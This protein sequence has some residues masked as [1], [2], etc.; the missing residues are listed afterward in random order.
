MSLIKLLQKTDTKKRTFLFVGNDDLPI[1]E[2]WHS[3][4]DKGKV[5][6]TDFEMDYDALRGYLDE[7]GIPYA[8]HG[9]VSADWVF[10][11]EAHDDILTLM[12]FLTEVKGYAQLEA[13]AHSNEDDEKIAQ[14][15][16]RLVGYAS[17]Y[18]L[19]AK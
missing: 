1:E 5:P 18:K 3:V 8:K 19:G 9:E 10:K 12:H 16:A 14:F 2:V 15:K 13:R 11:L 7:K 4:S 6:S 17:K